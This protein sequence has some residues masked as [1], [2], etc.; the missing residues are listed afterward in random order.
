MDSNWNNK[1]NDITNVAGC[2]SWNTTN[3]ILAKSLICIANIVNSIY[4][5]SC[6]D[7]LSR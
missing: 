3:K 6:F 4:K 1:I 2:L 7:L 5:I